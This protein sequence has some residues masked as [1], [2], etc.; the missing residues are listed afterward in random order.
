[1]TNIIL[2]AVL[3]ILAVFAY[4]RGKGLLFS[5]ITAFYPAIAVYK[6]FPYLEQFIVAKASS[7]QIFLSHLGVFI[8]IFLPIFFAVSRITKA[9]SSRSGIKGVID[10]IL[11][12]ASVTCLSIVL[13]LHVLPERDVY[14]MTSVLLNFFNSNLGY[15][16]S[17]VFPLGVIYYLSKKSYSSSYSSSTSSKFED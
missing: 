5:V 11:L 4:L 7:L 17:L 12:S 8:V 16:I 3:L 2:V 10:S 14:N 13:C 1:M 15:F 9:G 6:S